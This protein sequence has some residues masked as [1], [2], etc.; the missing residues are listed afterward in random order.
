MKGA[1]AARPGSGAGK[2]IEPLLA[3]PSHDVRVAAVAALAAEWAVTLSAAD[4]GKKLRGAEA[5]A[6][7]R[8]VA[9]DALLYLARTDKRADVDAE[10]AKDARAAG[11]PFAALFATLGAALLGS[12]ADGPAFVALLVP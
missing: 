5:N 8:F 11:T 9:L 4:L 2:L 10:L 3:D 12:G 6:L 1:L 7:V